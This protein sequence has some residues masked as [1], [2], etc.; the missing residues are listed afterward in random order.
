MS[1]PN[2]SRAWATLKAIR[3]PLMRY[4][5]AL[6]LVAV[7]IALRAWLEPIMGHPSV[8]TF[9]AAILLCTGLEVLDR[10]FFAW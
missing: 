7:A 1:H 4:G 9:M 8:A 10:Q 5:F 3:S 2:S 6:V